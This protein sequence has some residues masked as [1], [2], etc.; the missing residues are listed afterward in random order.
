MNPNT[1][2]QLVPETLLKK[3]HDLDALQAQRAASA[4]N[5]SISRKRISNSKFKTV[6]IVKPETILMQSRQC[7]KSAIR[8]NRVS[9]KGMQKRASNKSVVKN[10]VWDSVKE[11]EVD[12][13]DVPEKKS[14]KEEDSDDDME[15]SD[16]EAPKESD[17]R[18][19][20]IPYK[21]NSI[22]AT[23]VFA[24]L[25]RPTIHTTPKPVKKTLSSL[26][27]RRMH[28][29]VFLPYN[30]VTRKMLHLVEPYVLYGV[31]S[32]ET[33][34]D[35][36]R[37]R[38]FCRVDGQRVPL[39]DN[40]VIERELGELGLIC[41]E[42]LVQVLSTASLDVIEG[43]GESGEAATFGKVA[44]FLW[45]FRL[46]ARKSKFQ[47]KMLDFKDGKL[48]GDQGEAMNGYIREML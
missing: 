16:N 34:S 35:L 47:R 14:E 12:E 11:E 29:G 43:G 10:K 18:L 20:N 28:E 9:K 17:N 37:R 19:Q 44:K 27:L 46:T 2:L 4:L 30:S 6:K 26:R 3:R 13:K 33:I 31:P 5:R 42:D 25:I 21:A 38:G 23:T 24:I 7:K 1:D 45:P 36:V 22:G 15:D 39:A 40:N 48:Y 8:Y 32:M 41:V